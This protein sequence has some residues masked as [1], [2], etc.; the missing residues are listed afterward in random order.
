MI[1]IIAGSRTAEH[2]HVVAA[3][4]ECPFTREIT[5]VVCGCANGADTHG[6]TWADFRGI[7]TKLFV[8]DWES[9]GASAGPIRNDEMARYAEPDGALILVWDGKSRGS[10]NMLRAALFRKLRIFEYVYKKD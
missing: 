4:L 6:A 8:A 2:H 9:Y 3:M 10:A 1:A 5:E 7:P